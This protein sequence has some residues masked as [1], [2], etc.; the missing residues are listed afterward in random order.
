MNIALVSIL[1]NVGSKTN[2]QGG[3]YGLIQTKM[4]FDE[5][6]H[7]TVDVNPPPSMWNNYDIIY[8]CEGVNFVEGSFNVPGGPQPIHT[9]KMKAM[10]DF[11]GELR[12][13]NSSFDFNKF[14]KRL[15][16]EATF[17]D[18]K[19]ISWYNTFLAHGI[20]NKK[21]VIGDS[22][23]LSVWKPGYSLD[24]TAGRTLHGFLKRN[25]SEA[26]NEIYNTSHI[27]IKFIDEVILYFGNI[28]LRFHLMRQDN[29]KQATIDLFTRYVEF[30]KQFKN[31]TLV[32]LLPVEHESRKI[33][34][35]GLYKK[36]P[37]FG[38]RGER[39]EI[40]EVANKIMNESGLKTIQW[41]EEWIDEDGTK[42][43]DIL[44]Q[45]SSVHLRP[46]NYP[47]LNEI[48]NVSK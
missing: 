19:H 44:E 5:H 28:D 16:I 17:P 9:E 6:P 30:A 2:T 24:F 8:V 29:P 43:L 46:K 10:A 37:F 33:P 4:L 42:M 11:K 1:G 13:S 45:K 12:F 48:L 15:K 27:P 25:T 39:M 35:T 47:Y 26:I 18:T 22:H 3:G 23:A 38:T 36:Q 34:G 7:D 40:R 20:Q 14:N 32:N 31:A 21:A 41:P